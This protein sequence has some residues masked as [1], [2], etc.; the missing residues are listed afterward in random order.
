SL[1][2]LSESSLPQLLVGYGND[3]FAQLIQASTSESFYFDHACAEG[4][5]G[6]CLMLFLLLWPSWRWR[7]TGS[8]GQRLL[9][10]WLITLN[11]LVVSVV[12][13]VWVNPIC[14]GATSALLYGIGP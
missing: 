6:L 1:A 3:R 9:L 11:A 7:R 10:A 14:D 13:N 8:A 2:L 4:F 12:G 5:L